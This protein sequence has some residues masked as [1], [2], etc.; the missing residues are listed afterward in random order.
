MAKYLSPEIAE[1]GIQLPVLLD[2]FGTSAHPAAIL[3]SSENIAFRSNFAAETRIHDRRF[4][5]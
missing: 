1:P 3:E 2:P 5:L 4:N